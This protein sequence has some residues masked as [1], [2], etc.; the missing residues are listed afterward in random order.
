[1]IIAPLRV[2][3]IP[4][5]EQLM[6][7]GE[8]YITVRSS[9]DYWMYAQLFSSTCPVALIDNTPTGA[10]VAFRSQDN[11]DDIYVQDVVVHPHHRGKGITRQL[12]ERV[13]IYGLE[14]GCRRIYLTS[15]PENATAHQTWLTLGFTNIPGDTTH[16]G[17]AVIAN[18]KGPGKD[19]AV[20]EL[21]L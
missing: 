8:P 6:A 7:T 17:V 19:R 10:I 16:G 4:Q 15:E 20:Y 21:K 5:I 3:L 13:R 12:L 1:M 2:E 18:F 11:P 9:S 14:H